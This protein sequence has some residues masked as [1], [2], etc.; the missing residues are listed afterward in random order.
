M[1]EEFNLSDKY[2]TW[3]LGALLQKMSLNEAMIIIKNIE[4]DEREFIKLLK[5]GLD[6]MLL[7]RHNVRVLIDKLAGD[8]LTKRMVTTKE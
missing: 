8:K 5:E 3:L 1:S 2:D 4:S 7:V 6:D